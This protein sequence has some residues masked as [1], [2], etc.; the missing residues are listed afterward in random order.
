M[1]KYTKHQINEIKTLPMLTEDGKGGVL[2]STAFQ[3][4]HACCPQEHT[5]AVNICTRPTLHWDWTVQSRKGVSQEA[6]PLLMVRR[7]SMT[8]GGGRDKSLSVVDPC[9]LARLLQ[10]LT[11]VPVSKPNQTWVTH[12]HIQDCQ[13]RGDSWEEWSAGVGRRWE[14]VIRSESLHNKLSMSGSQSVCDNPCQGHV[15]DILYIRIL[16]YNL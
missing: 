6:P 8:A 14:R 16:Y 1:Q 5:G 4:G 7:Q 10:T 3:V 11:R 9:K 2:L 12:K 13:S 15:S